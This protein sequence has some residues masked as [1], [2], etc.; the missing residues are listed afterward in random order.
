[1]KNEI[2]LNEI[3]SLLWLE[4]KHFG[5]YQYCIPSNL[6]ILYSKPTFNKGKAFWTL[7]E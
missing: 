5:L 7:I 3:I 4:V 2:N 6:N 1:M